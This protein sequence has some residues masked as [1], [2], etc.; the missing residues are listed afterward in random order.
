[1]AKKRDYK[2]EYQRRI[3]SGLARGLTR[4]QAA[5]HPKSGEPSASAARLIN[6][7]QKMKETVSGFISGLRDALKPL[8]KSVTSERFNQVEYTDQYDMSGITVLPRWSVGE[9]VNPP[10]LGDTRELWR[11]STLYRYQGAYTIVVCGTTEEDYP[12]HDKNNTCLSYRVTRG[13]IN[14]AMT[15]KDVNDVADLVNAMLPR[16]REENWLTVYKFQVLDK[17]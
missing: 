14:R 10:T 12:G 13:T 8:P 16:E 15:R 9:N 3:Q 17:E 11:T 4:S 7:F 2:A 6:P 1:M 5:G